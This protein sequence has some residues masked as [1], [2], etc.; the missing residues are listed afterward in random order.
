MTTVLSVVSE[1]FPLVKT[2][3]LGDVTAAL[4][5]ALG[6][7]GVGVTTLIPG[8]PTVL[9][10]LDRTQEVRRDSDFFGGAARLLAGRAGGLDL[11]VIDAPHLYAR[12]GNPYVGPDG[13]D[14]P[15]NGLRFGALGWM[16]ARIGIGDIAGLRPDIVHAHDW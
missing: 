6:D 8:Y 10:A 1:L 13:H 9:A 15:D 14:W 4:P 3:G 16:A 7:L 12:P 5:A 2:G 11:L